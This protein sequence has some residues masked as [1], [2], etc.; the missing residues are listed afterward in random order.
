M[1]TSS[2]SHLAFIFCH[3]EI[4]HNYILI[5]KFNFQFL[6]LS[7]LLS[8]FFFGCAG[9][10]LPCG[11]FSSCREWRLLFILVGRLLTAAASLVAKYRL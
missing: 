11:R 1:P 4:I 6:V 3:I 9:S 10:L 7:F 5:F 8:N 2:E